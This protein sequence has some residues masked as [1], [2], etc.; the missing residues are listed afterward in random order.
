[1]LKHIQSL[2][3]EKSH[4]RIVIAVSIVLFVVLVLIWIRVQA[5]IALRNRTNAAATPVVAVITAPQ[6]GGIESIVLPGNVQAWHEA[7]LYA[8]TSGYIKRWLVDIG[9][10]VKAGDLLAQI[11]TPELG[12]VNISYNKNAQDTVK[13]SVESRDLWDADVTLALFGHD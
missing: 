6:G 13:V 12:K 3:K 2:V 1:M 4:Q 9:S 8:R 11:E 10:H 7:T 5:A